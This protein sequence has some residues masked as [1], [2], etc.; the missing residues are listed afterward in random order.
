MSNQTPGGNADMK[1]WQKEALFVLDKQAEDDRILC[2]EDDKDHSLRAEH[3]QFV[4]QWG[5][6]Y[7]DIWDL[8][9]AIAMFILPRLA[10][11]R[12]NSCTVP[13][14]TPPGGGEPEGM[15]DLEWCR[16]L[17]M[18]CDGLHLYLEKGFQFFTEEEEKLWKEAKQAL[19]DYFEVLW[20]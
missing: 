11:F 2:R 9:D 14:V 7:N 19:F 16:I 8:D 13:M 20:N 5:F 17:D 1:N 10:Y 15:D 3:D 6:S 12:E 18:I 4:K